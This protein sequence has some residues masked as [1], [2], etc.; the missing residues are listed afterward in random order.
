MSE[1]VFNDTDILVLNYPLAPVRSVEIEGKK[2]IIIKNSKMPYFEMI[3]NSKDNIRSCVFSYDRK[4]FLS[5]LEEIQVVGEGDYYTSPEG[6]TL[7]YRSEEEGT[8]TLIFSLC[9]EK[10][11]KIPDGVNRIG[12]KAFA[13][14]DILS[15]KFPDSIEVIGYKSFNLCRELKAAEFGVNLKKISRCAFLSCPKLESVRLS[16][17][18]NGEEI[19][20]E[21]HVFAACKKLR[22]IELGRNHI[23]IEDHAFWGCES[24][25][26]VGL[27]AATEV[28]LFLDGNRIPQGIYNATCDRSKSVSL[29]VHIGDNLLILPKV[30]RRNCSWNFDLEKE[31][32]VVL[33]QAAELAEDRQ[34][35][36]LEGYAMK[37]DL[38]TKRFLRKYFLEMLGRAKTEENFLSLF[39]KFRD[40]HLLTKSLAENSLPV[41]QE[42]DW[43]QATAYVLEYLNDSSENSIK[44]HKCEAFSL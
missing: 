40:L 10:H 34:D 15:V 38:E 5:E 29:K 27:S 23:K 33:Y 43:T 35:I 30:R 7:F 9:K 28:D 44:D 16:D 37:P 36:A 14:S 24:L 4:S 22:N 6:D 11:M 18:R 21:N 19:L 39:C 41:A 26:T 20:I 13:N 25:E 3:D 12:F 31:K 8:V 17:N 32:I 42:K 1:K 2:K